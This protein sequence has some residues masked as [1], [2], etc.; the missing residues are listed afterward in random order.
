M[1]VRAMPLSFPVHT[2]MSD[3]GCTFSSVK[4][5]SLTHVNFASG[6]NAALIPSS[7]PPIPKGFA[8]PVAL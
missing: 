7:I 8:G 1:L 5:S 3:H 2:G 4:N 6:F